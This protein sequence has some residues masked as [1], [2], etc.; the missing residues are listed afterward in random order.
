VRRGYWRER[1]GASILFGRLSALIAAGPAARFGLRFAHQALLHHSRK[2]NHVLGMDF[3]KIRVYHL[4]VEMLKE[5][6][7]LLAEIEFGHVG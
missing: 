6:F 4:H 5:D 3:D 7:G 2:L 1:L